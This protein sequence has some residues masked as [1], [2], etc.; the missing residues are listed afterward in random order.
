MTQVNKSHSG[1]WN[2]MTNV[3]AKFEINVQIVFCFRNE[4]RKIRVQGKYSG[5]TVEYNEKLIRLANIHKE[6]IRQLWSPHRFVR[7]GTE[8]Q[9]MWWMNSRRDT[10]AWTGKPNSVGRGLEIFGKKL[11]WSNLFTTRR[12]T[13]GQAITW[14][15]VGAMKFG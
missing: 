5:N 4:P 3:S 10:V 2:T 8:K 14:C 7:K 11:L 1:L 9:K 6:L 12:S 15:S 13:R